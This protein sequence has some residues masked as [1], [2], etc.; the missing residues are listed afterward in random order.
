MVISRQEVAQLVSPTVNSP[1]EL[2]NKRA[3]TTS[4]DNHSI[5][6]TWHLSYGK[7][8]AKIDSGSCTACIANCEFSTRVT[9][10]QY[11]N[12][13]HEKYNCV[14]FFLSTLAG[15]RADT[16]SCANHSSSYTLHLMV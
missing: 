11:A 10:L 4:C 15:G 5:S 3:D 8:Y 12:T 9:T 6:Y 13:L 7:G 14:G 2:Q 16:T 1:P